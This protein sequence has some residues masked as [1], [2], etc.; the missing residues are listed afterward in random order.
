MAP[1]TSEV[2]IYFFSLTFFSPC[3]YIIT[4]AV[5]APSSLSL[6]YRIIHNHS[7]YYLY[8][9]LHF[10]V[11]II[12]LSHN[13][14]FASSLCYCCNFLVSLVCSFFF[15]LVSF[16]I[17]YILSR[18]TKRLFVVGLCGSNFQVPFLALELWIGV[19]IDVFNSHELLVD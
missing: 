9:Y 4:F 18:I 10:V 3:R 19:I 12:L 17:L 7:S 14:A 1:P 11:Y 16:C 2:V 15:R 8:L 6:V 13:F 5:F